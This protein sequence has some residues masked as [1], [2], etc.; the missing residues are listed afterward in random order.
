MA[1]SEISLTFPA[2]GDRRP[3]TPVLKAI[4]AQAAQPVD[5][6]LA[7]DITADKDWRNDYVDLFGRATLAA[8][9]S[10]EAAIE[11]ARAGLEAMHDTLVLAKDA[12]HP[13]AANEVVLS[14]TE[15]NATRALESQT[16][17]GTAAAERELRVPY[18]GKQLSGQQLIDQLGDWVERQIVEPSFAAA[19]SEVVRNP[20]WLSLP[21]KRVAMIGAGSEMGPLEPLLRWGVDVLAI[22]LPLDRVWDRIR[23]KAQR[24][25]GSVTAAVDA[26]GTI[27]HKHVGPLQ[28][29]DLERTILPLLESLKR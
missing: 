16:I 24:G 12:E 4:L 20:E 7:K 19:I 15:L 21:G 17:P 9:S 29:R 1:E 3:S 23:A 10:K 22:D 11:M 18:K 2:D 8:A 6:D 28:P 26:D 5:A 25:A 13:N 14:K 27:V